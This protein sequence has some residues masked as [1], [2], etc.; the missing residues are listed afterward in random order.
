[1]S[2]QDLRP[3]AAL[4]CDLIRKPSVTPADE[5]CQALLAKRLTSA[6]FSCETMR[7]GEVTNL[8]ARRGSVAPLLCFAGHTDVVPVG[9]RDDWRTDPFDPVCHNDVVYGRGAVDMKGGLAAMVVAAEEF[10]RSHDSFDGSLAFLITS[11]EEGPAENGTRKVIDALRNRGEE[12]TWCIIGEPSSDSQPGDVIRIG[13]RGSLSGRLVVRGVQGHV[14]YPHLA[15]NPIHRLA[16]VLSELHAINWNDGD[17]EFPET[18]VQT[19]ELQS[20]A[21]AANVIPAEAC[22]EFN[23]RYSPKWTF[24]ALQDAI[25]AVVKSHA[26]EYRLDWHLYGEPFLTSGGKLIDAA[27]EAICETTGTSPRLS[28]GGG[29]S[30]GR[31]IQPAGADVVELGLTNATAHK[32]NECTRL[33]HLE[34]LV[35]QYQIILQKMLLR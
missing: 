1:M 12:I 22:A 16:T 28:T 15:D 26:T 7:F 19:V 9:Q 31:F 30:D 20:G 35:E 25:E 34:L 14:A 2:T 17:D 5:G 29:T 21:G 6:G 13:R 18:S 27:V 23:L 3:A 24:R 10:L 32:A 8:W 4:M 11:D 33:D